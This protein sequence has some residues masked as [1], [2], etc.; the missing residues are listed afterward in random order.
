M[1]KSLLLL[2]MEEVEQR[3]FACTAVVQ[4]VHLERAVEIFGCSPNEVTPDMRRLAKQDNYLRLYSRPPSILSLT[5]FIAKF[6]SSREPV[7]ITPS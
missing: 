3:V 5:E 2:K 1:V 4:D 6:G 7:D